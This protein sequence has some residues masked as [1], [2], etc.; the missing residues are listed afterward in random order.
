M[1]DSDPNIDG[2]VQLDGRPVR[3]LTL[4]RFVAL[5]FF[6]T[7]GGPFGLEEAVGAGG[8]FYCL[9]GLV[10]LPFV[11]AIPQSLMTAEL[12]TMMPDNGG[13]FLWVWRA[14]GETAGVVNAYMTLASS[15]LDICL[16]PNL[17]ASYL[18]GHLGQFPRWALKISI[19]GVMSLC[20]AMGLDLVGEV[21][22]ALLVASMSVF[23]VEIPYAITSFETGPWSKLPLKPDW[24]LFSSILLWSN[25][26]WDALGSIAGEVA[27]PPT[28]YPLGIALALVASTCAFVGPV[29]ISYSLLPDPALWT[30]DAFYEAA[31]QASPW[32]AIW[33]RAACV[34]GSVGQLNAGMAST[35]RRIWAMASDTSEEQGVFIRT[36]PL[37]LSYLSP[38][39]GTPVKAIVAQLVVTGAIVVLDFSQLVQFE[40]IL[41]CF[42]LL[43]E[44]AAFIVLKYTEP[45]T[46]RPYV[47]PFGLTGAWAITVVK[48]IV[49]LFTIGSIGTRTPFLLFAAVAV[50]LT[51]A[52]IF[53]ALRALGA[54]G[55]PR[56]APFAP[57]SRQMFDDDQHP[58]L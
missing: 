18:P 29:A 56:R 26:G 53:M 50:N 44:F 20:N 49:V 6:L 19:L 39:H 51:T 15:F 21:S 12:S 22:I 5:G 17:I 47:V 30:A 3:V 58:L 32:L 40:M 23:A 25:T 11:W 54:L 13:S 24:A 37:F 14:L 16:Y 57:E 27:D 2:V 10:L 38:K 7:C 46:P 35:S 36:M 9:L 4:G 45:M 52:L 34:C 31:K 1:P 42:N 33:V 28:T 41:Q 8:V 43:L 55:P 48:T